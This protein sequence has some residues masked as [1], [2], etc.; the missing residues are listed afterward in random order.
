ML[1]LSTL[2]FFTLLLSPTLSQTSNEYNIIHFDLRIGVQHMC[3]IFKAPPAIPINIC[4]C[5]GDN[6]SGQLGY[7]DTIPR[8][9]SIQDLGEF[10]PGV[11]L[12]TGRFAIHVAVGGTGGGNQGDIGRSCAILDTGRVKCM[13]DNVTI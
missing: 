12:G 5:L 2:F 10:L 4:K 8:G 1:L 9:T 11:N 3:I 13:C 7:E 6:N